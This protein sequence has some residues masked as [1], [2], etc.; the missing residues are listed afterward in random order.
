MS[1]S[2]FDRLAGNRRNRRLR[3]FWFS[4]S[5][6]SL[7]VGAILALDPLFSGARVREG[8]MVMVGLFLVVSASTGTY[9][10]L[11]FQTRE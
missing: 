9:Y 4:A 8:W 10:H 11:K 1:S 6:V 3:N 5:A 7:F 2:V